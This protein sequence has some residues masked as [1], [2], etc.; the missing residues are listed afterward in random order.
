MAR[1]SGLSTIFRASKFS[2]LS[3]Q[4]DTYRCIA[5]VY[6]VSLG[7]LICLMGDYWTIGLFCDKWWC[8]KYSLM[9]IPES[10]TEE[11]L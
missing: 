1:V 7:A 2:N 11:K 6:I 4:I 5:A 8:P 10:I 3:I 9:Q